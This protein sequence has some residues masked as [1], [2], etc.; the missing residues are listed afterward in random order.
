MAG[1]S[2]KEWPLPPT[3]RY[4]PSTPGARST[5]MLQSGV[6]VYRPDPACHDLGIREMR[7]PVRQ[8]SASVLDECGIGPAVVV[9]GGDWFVFLGMADTD[10]DGAGP[11][12][13]TEVY[14]LDHV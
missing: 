8:S 10:E 14:A 5:I 7:H 3:A 11:L 6:I 9:V 4:M 2:L 12:G 13:R 1:A